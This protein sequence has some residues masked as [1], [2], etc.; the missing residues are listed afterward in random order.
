MTQSL[1]QEHKIVLQALEIANLAHERV[2][3]VSETTEAL[4]PSEIEQLEATYSN[5]LS[6][7]KL[8]SV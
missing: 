4:L 6:G 5:D 8:D 2:V 7:P 3:T 1:R